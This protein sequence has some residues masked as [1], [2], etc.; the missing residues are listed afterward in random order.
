MEHRVGADLLQMQLE[1]PSDEGEEK[2]EKLSLEELLEIRANIIRGEET[3]QVRTMVTL[4]EGPT[5]A[6]VD[7]Q[8][9]GKGVLREALVERY[10]DTVFR[11]ELYH[12]PPCRGPYDMAHITLK[13]NATPQRAKTFTMHGERRDAYAKVTQDWLDKGFIES[14]P[15]G[16]S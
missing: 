3:A 2:N 11:N 16:K 15:T 5:N 7:P 4:Q 6:G 1:L 10:K 13:E 8:E 9:E 12:D 14:P